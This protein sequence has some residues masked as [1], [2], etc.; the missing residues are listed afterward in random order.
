MQFNCKIDEQ[1]IAVP[2][3]EFYFGV[4]DNIF[5]T[6]IPKDLYVATEFKNAT[7]YLRFTGDQDIIK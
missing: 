1:I 4:G 3:D 2:E 5:D 7:G 6:L